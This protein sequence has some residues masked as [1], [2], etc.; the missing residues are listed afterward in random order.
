MQLDIVN[1]RMRILRNEINVY[2]KDTKGDLSY[3]IC[4]SF[5]FFKF[6]TLWAK[7]MMESLSV[8]WF[9]IGIRSI[10]V[11]LLVSVY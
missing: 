10:S 3:I 7:G 4:I 6:Q 11:H 2:I 5:L 9:Y 8:I 1:I